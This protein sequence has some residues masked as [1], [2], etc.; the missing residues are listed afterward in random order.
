MRSAT[1]ARVL[2]AAAALAVAVSL[3]QLERDHDRCQDAVRGAFLAS[4]GQEPEPLLQ[5][6]V[7]TMVRDCSTGEPLS[8]IAVGVRSEHS[9]A[10][11]RLARAAVGRE[12]ESYVPWAVLATTGRPREAADAARRAR[13]LN[14]LSASA[15]G[16]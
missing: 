13:A 14:P 4:Q 7:D 15:G 9:R 11:A 1:I 3:I 2:T 10:A 12:P 6:R 5:S 8:D 16:P